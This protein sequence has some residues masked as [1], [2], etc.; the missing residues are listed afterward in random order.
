MYE[1]FAKYYDLLYGDLNYEGDCRFLDAV[2]RRFLSKG[3]ASILDLGCGTGTHAV[4]LGRRGSEVTG[5]DLSPGQLRVARAKVRG[6]TLP[7]TFVRGDMR[8]FDLARSFDAAICMFGGFGYLL[9]DRDVRAHL[10]SVRRHLGPRGVYV[11]EFW[12]ESGVKPGHRSWLHRER[13]FRLIR[14]DESHYDPKRHRLPFDMHFFAFEGNR[15]KETFTESHTVR[16]YRVAEVRALLARAGLRLAG[17]YAGDGD[18]KGFRPVR[19]S[20]FRVMAVAKT[21]P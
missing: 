16:L 13:P 14:L 9:S 8:R 20:T 11:F 7:V 1:R 2:F 17:A 10:R 19:R 12:Q 6:T 3:P 15:L 5:L 18:R 4:L 21:A